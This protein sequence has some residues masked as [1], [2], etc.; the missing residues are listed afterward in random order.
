MRTVLLLICALFAAA[1][2]GAVE[3]K[4]LLWDSIQVPAY[5]QCAADFSR[6]N[7]G[8]TI[9][10]RQFGYD[11]YWT[12]LSMGFIAG[13]APDVFANH[14]SKLPELAANGLLV[15]LAPYVRRD[16]L[17]TTQYVGRLYD[18][19][20]RGGR[21]W[22]LP[23]DWDTIALAVNLSHA[24]RA[25]VTLAE[26]QAL[27]WNPRDG[28]SLGRVIRR[29]TLDAEG[30]N[31]TQPGFDRRRVA[32]YGYQNPGPGGM[33][34]QTEWSHFAYSNG[35]RY[36]DAPWSPSF[37]YDDPRLAETIAWLAGLPAQGVS[38]SYESAKGLGSD[39]M[40][41]AGRVAMVP[42]GAWMTSYFAKLKFDFAWVPLPVGPSGRRASMLNGVADSIWSG[43][44]V[45]DEAW[46]W[47]RYLGSAECQRVVA[48]YG[49][50]FPA[51]NGMAELA[52]EAQHRRGIDATAFLTMA[53]AE[54]FAAPIADN[55]AEVD[56][57][58]KQAIESVL[59]GRETAGPA[60][61]R[62]NEAANRLM[63]RRR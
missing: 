40:F 11:D 48:G 42:E 61:K 3:I 39:A 25:G 37:R 55:A 9:K 27:D 60:L 34:G 62:A 16:G 33:M 7:P 53:D 59:I 5:R 4:Y 50:V 1:R 14:L 46:R 8:I 21:Q 29:L 51:L 26:L 30:R 38:A 43:S 2:A 23:K 10:I 49:V 41:A 54:T 15:D 24:R 19:W 18:N 28:G 13:S 32:V 45:K 20:G 36:Q 31:A 52:V 6:L 56:Q 17:D 44:R 63:Q 12:T 22:G 47:V 58:L 57:V 35:F